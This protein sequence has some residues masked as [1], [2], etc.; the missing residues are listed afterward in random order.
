M[1]MNRI[2]KIIAAVLVLGS[3][4]A[5]AEKEEVGKPVKI[6]DLATQHETEFGGVYIEVT[7][8]DFNVTSKKSPSSCE[9]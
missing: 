6:E 7:I 4:T 2:R 5:C 8:D 3:M 1:V 9:V